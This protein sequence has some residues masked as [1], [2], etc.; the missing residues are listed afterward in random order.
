MLLLFCFNVSSC[1]RVSQ[2]VAGVSTRNM[3]VG[4]RGKCVDLSVTQGTQWRFDG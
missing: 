1:I 3:T 4:G 2:D